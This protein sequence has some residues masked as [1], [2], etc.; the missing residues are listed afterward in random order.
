MNIFF[1]KL[2]KPTFLYAVKNI[3][4][5]VAHSNCLI[6]NLLN[7]DGI[8][9]IEVSNIISKIPQI[10]KRM[11][12]SK[13]KNKFLHDF[14]ALLYVYSAY[15]KSESTVKSQRKKI[16]ALF[17]KRLLRHKEYFQGN[18]VLRSSYLFCHYVI[19]Y[20]TNNS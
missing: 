10:G 5:A 15:V 11:R 8:P 12:D 14:V 17:Y 18:I 6:N 7:Q 1:R 13:L 2:V 3:R 4:N 9:N 19:K 16:K 20:F